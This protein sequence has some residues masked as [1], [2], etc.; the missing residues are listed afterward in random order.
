M[1]TTWLQDLGAWWRSGF[2]AFFEPR[3][4]AENARLTE[5]RIEFLAMLSDLKG[6]PVLVLRDRI[7]HARSL[8]EL[9]HLRT[10]LFSVV[11]VQRDQAEAQDRLD[12][13]NRYFPTRSPRSG[14][15][16]LGLPEVK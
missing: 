11:A 14:F 2:P 1:E 8:T 7:R 10:D 16:G 13:L 5:A 12:W 15:G 4:V 3:P 6:A 9:W